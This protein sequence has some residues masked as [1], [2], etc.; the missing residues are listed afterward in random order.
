MDINGKA[1]PN[2][3]GIDIFKFYL[4]KDGFIPFGGDGASRN[5]ETFCNKSKNI[6]ASGWAC[7]AW[8]MLNENMDYLHCEDLSWHGKHKCK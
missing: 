3:V 6:I 4:T 2:T 7:A 1:K 8:V 5:F